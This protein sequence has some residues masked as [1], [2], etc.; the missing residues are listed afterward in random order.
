M[1]LP[2]HRT[3]PD[4]SQPGLVQAV[5]RQLRIRLAT[6]SPLNIVS[7]IGGIH[8]AWNN[9]SLES[10]EWQRKFTFATLATVQGLKEWYRWSL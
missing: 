5:P 7:C 6:W 4:P 3:E 1:C 2:E 8:I 9:N 10:K